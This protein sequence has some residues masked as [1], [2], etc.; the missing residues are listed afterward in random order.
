MNA[1]QILSKARELISSPSNWIQKTYGSFFMWDFTRTCMSGAIILTDTGEIGTLLTD[2]GDKASKYLEE[3]VRKLD[4][5]LIVYEGKGR[6]PTFNDKHTHRECLHA[7]D[8]AI[9]DASKDYRLRLVCDSGND[10]RNQA[11]SSQY[12]ETKD[13][14]GI[15]AVG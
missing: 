2:E 11:V 1:L 7:Y 9:S 8:I 14:E 15:R 6:T 3:A 5:G 10:A 12:S 4:P 13:E